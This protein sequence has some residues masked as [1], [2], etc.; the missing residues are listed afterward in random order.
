MTTHEL[1]DAERLADRIAILVGGGSWR[2][3]RGGLAARLPRGCGSGS[4][5]HST[6]RLAIAGRGS[7]GGSPIDGRR[8]IVRGPRAGPA[9]AGLVAALRRGALGGRPDHESRT[10]GGTLE[11]TYLELVGGHGHGGRCA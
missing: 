7:R 1:A 2:R 8:H 6:R 11:D 10:I 3:E 4:I 9:V 5:G